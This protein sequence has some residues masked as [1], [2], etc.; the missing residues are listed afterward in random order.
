MV[1]KRKSGLNKYL[2][3]FIMII[4]KLISVLNNLVSAVEEEAKLTGRNLIV[5][6]V[7]AL[8]VLSLL[9]SA[10]VVIFALLTV[11]LIALKFSLVSSLFITL[12]LNLLLL[13]IVGFCIMAAKNKLGFAKSAQLFRDIPRLED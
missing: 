9:V 1:K 8:L 2:L 5:L 3:Y 13:V 7:L 12:I 10:W 4:P 11:Y 6:L